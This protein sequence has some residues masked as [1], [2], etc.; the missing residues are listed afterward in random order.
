MNST[1]HAECCFLLV[2]KAKI[3]ILSFPFALGLCLNFT[4][5]EAHNP[6]G[7]TGIPGN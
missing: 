5:L 6:E 7:L 2:T 4:L 1:L 3:S